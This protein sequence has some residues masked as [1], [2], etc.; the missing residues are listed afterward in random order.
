MLDRPHRVVA[1]RLGHLSKSDLGPEHLLVG[2][3][4]MP[5]LKDQQDSNLHRAPP[6]LSP[7]RGEGTTPRRIGEPLI[8]ASLAGALFFFQQ[9][10][11]GEAPEGWPHPAVAD[12][13]V[14]VGGRVTRIL[15]VGRPQRIAH[16]SR[17]EPFVP[18][19]GSLVDGYLSDDMDLLYDLFHGFNRWL[20]DGGGVRPRWPHLRSPTHRDG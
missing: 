9:S 18:D 3:V 14:G 16:V 1:E 20:D 5:V 19:A 4:V 6:A 11:G 15:S 2:E 17:H 8:M 10:T 12:T 7:L 13:D